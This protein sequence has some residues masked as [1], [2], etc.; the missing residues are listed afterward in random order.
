MMNVEIS[1]QQN[2]NKL[3]CETRQLGSKT[4]ND[5]NCQVNT[6]WTSRH[7][8]S[9]TYCV[10]IQ[11]TKV[12]TTDGKSLSPVDL[13]GWKRHKAPKIIKG[14]LRESVNYP[15]CFRNS[16]LNNEHSYYMIPPARC[17]FYNTTVWCPRDTLGYVKHYFGKTAISKGLTCA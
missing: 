15:G 1:Q 13:F 5:N 2:T 14:V 10:Q 17:Q 7:L 16:K 9:V 4:L 6:K 3:I 8:H 12:R 11:M